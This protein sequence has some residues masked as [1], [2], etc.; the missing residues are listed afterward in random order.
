MTEIDK[1]KGI[2]A[3]AEKYPLYGRGWREG[4]GRWTKEFNALTWVVSSHPASVLDVGCGHN[5]F[6]KAFRDRVPGITATGVDFACPGA[7]TIADMTLLPF[8]DK[9]F[10][11]LTSYDALEHLLPEDVDAALSEMARVSR[12]FIF[13]ISY[14]LSRQ[15][16]QGLNLH[17][18]VKSSSWW[19]NRIMRAGGNS[20]KMKG[21]YITGEWQLALKFSPS[22][23]CILVGNGPS[24]LARERGSQIDLFDEVIRFNKF[25]IN[26][27]EKHVGHKTTI[28]ST[29]GRGV[30]PRD[31]EN[32]PN[33]VIFT[34]GEGDSGP[35][36]TPE[37]LYRIPKYFY[38]QNR[39]ALQQHSFWRN[40]LKAD[41]DHLLSSSG[42]TVAD[43]LL[44][45]VGIETV[46]IIGF[47]HFKKDFSRQHHYWNPGSFK[48]PNEHD[49]DT[50]AV[51]FDNL[52]KAGRI[53]YLNAI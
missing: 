21:R 18:T 13:S 52:M 43:W 44:Q 26:G 31:E 19:I 10:D 34:H 14:V 32:R 41:A 5:D 51:M 48:R 50:E 36:Y 9:E 1:Y 29:Y 35:A 17:P 3:S 15:E 16:W 2:Y 24:I 47:D 11:I 45:V 28:W 12:R 6:I 7:D 4:S 37:L 42:L 22:S 46:T 38:K 39:R 53:K 25:Q 23:R 8:G 40:G 49:G 30:V 27:F 20:I 33:R